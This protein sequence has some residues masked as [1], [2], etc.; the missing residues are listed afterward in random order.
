MRRGPAE[1]CHL[2]SRPTRGFAVAEVSLDSFPQFT[3]GVLEKNELATAAGRAY[4]RSYSSHHRFVLLLSS[5]PLLLLFSS[6]HAPLLSFWRCPVTACPSFVLLVCS[7]CL[8]SL[9]LSSS[10][11]LLMFSSG[12]SVVLLLSCCLRLPTTTIFL[13]D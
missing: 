5:L 13:A 10:V 4:L 11:V 2:H 7:C 12:L 8:P 6:W 9:I 1:N 3:V